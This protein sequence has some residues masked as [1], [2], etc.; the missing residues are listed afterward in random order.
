MSIF[1]PIVCKMFHHVKKVAY[2]LKRQYFP[3]MGK[4][5]VKGGIYEVRFIEDNGSFE[6]GFGFSETHTHK[7]EGTAPHHPLK[8]QNA[9]KEFPAQVQSDNDPTRKCHCR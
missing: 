4:F 7:A 3:G 2:L 1:Y 5:V 9:I 8:V 6:A